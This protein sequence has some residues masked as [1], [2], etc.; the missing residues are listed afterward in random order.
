MQIVF[1][2][3]SRNWGSTQ[4]HLVGLALL[5]RAEHRLMVHICCPAGSP[6]AQKTKSL[7][8]PLLALSPPYSD[9]W[10]NP[11]HFLRLWLLTRAHRYCI[12][13]TFSDSAARLGLR[14]QQK[15]KQDHTVII[16]NC[17]S[18]H[19]L[20]TR[21]EQ[22]EMPDWWQQLHTI[23]CA[24]NYVRKQLLDSGL[25]AMRVIR[26]PAGVDT[27]ALSQHISPHQDRCVILS[28]T[29]HT[30]T[31][32]HS[33]LLKTM[34]A[35]WQNET[36]PPWEV[37]IVGQCD[38]YQDLLAEATALGV[39]S[40]LALV[41]AQPLEEILPYGHIVVSPS[42]S[43]NGSLPVMAAAWAA[44]LPLLC[45]ATATN[46]EWAKHGINALLYKAEDPQDL[47]TCLK[48]VMTDQALYHT[49]STGGQLSVHLTTQ[50]TALAH[51]RELYTQ[52]MHKHGWVLP[53]KATGPNATAP[54]TADSGII[55]DT[56]PAESPASA[57]ISA[58]TSDKIS[59]TQAP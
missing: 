11:L 48:S 27:T 54:N 49:L 59:E 41:Q 28:M 56:G 8:L 42:T 7:G 2:D 53:A 46:K 35:L 34:A 26:L 23:L 15:R 45:P 1:M 19:S 20:A 18:V 4:A 36:I 51:T 5:L 30:D 29:S 43:H 33:V 10:W 14:V 52:C 31:A 47:A 22:G 50:D 57:T 21:N 3:F 58:K 6:L 38:N 39:Q 37:R 40:R 16:H 13:H 24:N 9:S 44:G 12:F 25:D 17:H 32:C 55:G